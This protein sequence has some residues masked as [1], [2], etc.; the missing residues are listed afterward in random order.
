MNEPSVLDY[1]KSIL[2]PWEKNKI[3]VPEVDL[4]EL[5]IR[6]TPNLVKED[7]FGLAS[8]LQDEGLHEEEAPEKARYGFPWKTVLLSTAVL[9]AIIS[10]L[11]LE[12]PERNLYPA[13]AGYFVSVVILIVIGVQSLD[14]TLLPLSRQFSAVRIK[15]TPLIL[16]L[17]LALFS[18]LAFGSHQFSMLNLFLWVSSMGLG[19]YA[20]WHPKSGLQNTLASLGHFLRSPKWK[21]VFTPW[22][23]LVILSVLLVLFFRFYR[24][25]EVPGEMFSDHAEKLLDVAD[26]L[27]GNYWIFFPR[28]TGR[29]AI[30]MYLTAAVSRVFNTG[31]SFMSL[32]I[33]TALA[34]LLTLP[35]IYLLGKEVGNRW[36]GLLAFLFAGIAYWPNIISRIGLRFPLYP[37]FAI[38]SSWVK[39]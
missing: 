37:L 23:L 14:L 17:I 35:F 33:G 8:S 13:L 15:G 16:S 39:L 9:L 34:G 29:E 11:L 18:F 20:L 30:Q 25:S 19:I 12:S 22:T 32:K 27:D 10:Q 7:P 24:L 3:R 26:V 6:E 5:E 36:T 38:E 2:N 1:L 4:D 31:L 21:V 28:N